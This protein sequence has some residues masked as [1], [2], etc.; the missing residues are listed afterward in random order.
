MGSCQ[1]SSKPWNWAPSISVLILFCLMRQEAKPKRGVNSEVLDF[2]RITYDP[3]PTG[4]SLL[5]FYSVP[6]SFNTF[7]RQGTHGHMEKR[8]AEIK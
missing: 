3:V 4:T 5:S 8:E 1:S 6:V 7:V 2:F